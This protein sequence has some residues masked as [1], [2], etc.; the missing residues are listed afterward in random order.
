MELSKAGLVGSLK[1][2]WTLSG[3]F[4]FSSTKIASDFNTY[5]LHN[6]YIQSYVHCKQSIV[7]KNKKVVYSCEFIT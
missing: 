7:Q 1:T 5:S 3:R 4:N 2:K 6:V